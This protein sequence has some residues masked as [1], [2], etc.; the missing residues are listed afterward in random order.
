[1]T[2]SALILTNLD[3]I[4]TAN[5]HPLDTRPDCFGELDVANRLLGDAPALRAAMDSQ[6]YLFFRRLLD[7]NWSSRHV[8]EILLKY[9][10]LGEIDD[11]HPIDDAVAG[12]GERR[13][14]RPTCVPSRA[15][16]VPGPGIDE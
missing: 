4:L 8:M 5:G 14:R 10:I 15:A 13:S 11:R 9:A 2:T 7:P 3:L 6:G 16:S 12:D 1:M